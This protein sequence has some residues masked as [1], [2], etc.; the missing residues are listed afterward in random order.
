M[1]KIQIS[2]SE[3]KGK[4]VADA[5]EEIGAKIISSSDDNL[6]VETPEPLYDEI[7]AQPGIVLISE[8]VKFADWK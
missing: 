1:R 8:D 7:A 6:E 2:C 4:S 3:G 5:I